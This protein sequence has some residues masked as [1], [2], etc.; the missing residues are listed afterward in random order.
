MADF[1]DLDSIL[2]VKEYEKLFANVEKSVLVARIQYLEKTASDTR[3]LTQWEVIRKN[4]KEQENL[5]KR[6][7][8]VFTV[9]RKRARRADSSSV[10][11]LGKEKKLGKERED[12]LLVSSNDLRLMVKEEFHKAVKKDVTPKIDRILSI[13]DTNSGD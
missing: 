6:H 12:A 1:G 2:A 7:T 8:P 3:S 11:A 10:P 13:L 5:P 4:R 9:Q